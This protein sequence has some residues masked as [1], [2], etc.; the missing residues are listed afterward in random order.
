MSCLAASWDAC[1]VLLG[2]VEAVGEASS[3]CGGRFHRRRHE[4][5]ATIRQCHRH[6][7]SKVVQLGERVR[8][9]AGHDKESV[10]ALGSTRGAVGGELL[11]TGA[12][13]LPV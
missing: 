1:F 12:P 4:P 10:G 11:L 7:R 5:P 8:R 2:C 6:T 3:P 13:P 9:G